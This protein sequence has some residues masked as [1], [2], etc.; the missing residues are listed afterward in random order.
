MYFGVVEYSL[1]LH[2]NVARI[3]LPK[4]LKAWPTDCCSVRSPVSSGQLAKAVCTCANASV[5]DG[6]QV[7]VSA[8]SVP[9]AGSRTQRA[10]RNRAPLDIPPLH[11]PR[12]K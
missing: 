7:T 9:R 3:I 11:R 6:N 5:N 4:A 1:A 12:V 8:H 2:L 10:R